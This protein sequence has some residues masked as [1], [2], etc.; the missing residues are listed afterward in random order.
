[1]LK[2]NTIFFGQQLRS[3]DIETSKEL[4]LACD[5]MIIMGSTLVV[6][7]AASF[8][9]IA[10]QNGALLA[11]INLSDTPIDRESDFI[12][13]IKISEFMNFYAAVGTDI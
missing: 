11:I 2:P 8:P 1:M 12:F 13:H 3:E 10:K 5:L 7:P 6:Q 9:L 4:S